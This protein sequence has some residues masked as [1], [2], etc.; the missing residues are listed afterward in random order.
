MKIGAYHF[1][2]FDSSG[3]TQAENFIKNVEKD[4]N[5]LPP[6]IDVEFYGSEDEKN[7]EEVVPQIE[8]MCN[9]LE[10]HYG[11]KPI[12]YCTYKAYRKYIKGNFDSERLWIR[13]VYT[14]P[15][16]IGVSKWKIWQY[17]DTVKLDGYKG[18][19]DCVDVN[20][21]NGTLDELKDLK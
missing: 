10:E 17:T 18:K 5:M 3:D 16:L 9:K 1:F 2:S 12:I 8:N 4:D 14:N 11:K 15:K 6:A 21:F 19:E 20:A 7:Q 13:S